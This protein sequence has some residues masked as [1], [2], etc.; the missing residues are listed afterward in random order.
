M[1]LL[2]DIGA[3][4]YEMGGGKLYTW[5]EDKPT[6]R[7]DFETE[8]YIDEEGF[9]RFRP[10]GTTSMTG[11]P[12]SNSMESLLDQGSCVVLSDAD[13]YRTEQALN[14]GQIIIYT[15]DGGGG[16]IHQIVEVGEDTGG[17]FCY[18]RGLN[19]AYRDPWKVRLNQISRVF[20]AVIATRNYQTYPPESG[21]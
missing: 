16:I 18:C 2:K 11:L 7:I 6:P 14:I 9:V 10:Y 3:W 15:K 12:N 19:N 20:V 5:S 1:G 4:L 17:W 13:V 21:D 8:P